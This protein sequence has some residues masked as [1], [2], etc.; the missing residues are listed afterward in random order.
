MEHFARSCQ[1]QEVLYKSEIWIGELPHSQDAKQ[2]FP[3]LQINA[4]EL[5]VLRENSCRLSLNTDYSPRR[6]K[7]NLAIDGGAIDSGLV[8]CSNGI[9]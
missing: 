3:L 7:H 2:T 5:S 1:L 6:F 4:C 9:V 8:T